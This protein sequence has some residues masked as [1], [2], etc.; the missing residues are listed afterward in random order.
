MLPKYRLP[1]EAE[2]EFA[3][4]ALVG[5]SASPQD[6]ILTDRRL[7]AWDGNTARYKRHDKK[8]GMM[9]ANFKR[10]R[11]DYM[12]VAG[13]LNDNASITAPVRAFFPNDYGLYNMSGNVNEWTSDTYRPMTSSTL[14]DVESQDLNPFRGN[15]FQTKVLDENGKIVEKDSLGRLRYRMVTTNEAS[16]RTNYKTGYA[17]DYLDGDSLS[18]V[19]YDFGVH[20]LISDKSKVI[21]GG[22]WADRLYWL[23]PGSRRYL[24]EDESSRTVGFRCAM[25]KVGG[26]TVA[27]SAGGIDYGSQ[28]K[29][30]VKR[31]YK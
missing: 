31:R 23:S 3:A 18:F 30:K 20:S 16:E 10:G 15:K 9:L 19:T 26:A 11:G 2:W 27:T 17:I 22:S 28:K 5:N 21:K 1:T 4:L 12:G 13:N 6:E 7:Y 24:D 8:Q 14:R 25:H 29:S